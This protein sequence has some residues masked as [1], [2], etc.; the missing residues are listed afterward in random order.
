MITFD[1]VTS[2]F[3]QYCDDIE[4]LKKIEAAYEFATSAHAGQQRQSKQPYIV[5][6]L[7]VSHILADLELDWEVICAALLHDTVEDT[8]VEL[9]TVRDQFGD[10][11]ASL[12]DS[13]TKI[14]RVSVSQ[15]KSR[16]KEKADTIRK[17]MI[18]MIH[19]LR[20]IFIKLADRWDNMKSLHHLDPVKRKRIAEETRIIYVPL[21]ER[22]GISVIK[23]ELENLCFLHLKPKLYHKYVRRVAITHGFIQSDVEELKS[24]IMERLQEKDLHCGIY[25]RYKT[26]YGLYRRSQQKL[27]PHYLNLNILTEDSLDCYRILGILHDSFT[28]MPGSTIK[29]FISVPRS[30][31][32]Q[33]LHTCI[34]FRENVYPIQ[35]RTHTMDRIANF[36]V[37]QKAD[38]IPGKQYKS[39]LGMLRDLVDEEQDSVHLVRRIQDVARKDQ[40]YVCTPKGDYWG[41]PS[42]SIVLDFAYRVHTEIGHHCYGAIMDNQPAG[43]FDE[44]KDGAYIEI[45]TSPDAYPKPEWLNRVKTTRSQNAIRTWL[46]MKKREKSRDFGREILKKEM[47]RFNL[48]FNEIILS[49]N[50]RE[51][52]QELGARDTIDLFSKVGRGIL[53]TRK[54]ISHFV[55]PSDFQKMLKRQTALLPRVFSF[56]FNRNQ[57]K[58]DDSFEIRDIEDVYIKLSQCCNPLPGDHVIGII[59]RK[60][61]I[62]VHKNDCQAIRHRPKDDDRVIK[63]KWAITSPQKQSVRMVLRTDFKPEIPGIV[64][65]LLI[66]YNLALVSFKL[67]SSQNYRT[68]ELE[69]ETF[70]ADQVD[71]VLRQFQRIKGVQKAQRL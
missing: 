67:S 54:V 60:H 50:F 22:L 13:L 33:A 46:E 42:N 36:G 30:N 16:R 70:S 64:F 40:V 5:H 27:R 35:I 26:A 51:T 15:E 24:A 39:W 3:T 43:I 68:M 9:E 20:V 55:S 7:A 44:L 18:G 69:L 53:S 37:L 2:R 4:A 29:D 31:A 57:K 63:I 61:G 14:K 66:R 8:N 10:G 17:I 12:V 11:V 19:D 25:E 28:P 34:L 65:A 52:I 62:S 71:K 32:Y 59:S 56:F 1:K 58:E 23:R 49:P 45:I 6:P 47:D 41:F 38:G 21:A 48:D